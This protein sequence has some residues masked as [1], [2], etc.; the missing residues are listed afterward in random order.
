[1]PRHKL[2]L[3]R[4]PS[5]RREPRT[6]HPQAAAPRVRREIE[7]GIW[8]NWVGKSEAALVTLVDQYTA[9]HPR[10]RV[11]LHLVRDQTEVEA[12]LAAGAIDVLF[13]SAARLGEWADQGT[14]APLTQYADPM[15]VREDTSIPPPAW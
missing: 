5:P 14:I 7:L 15:W 9:L 8:H 2:R 10:V 6:G 13:W 12:G 11:T 4:K 3:Q 1:M